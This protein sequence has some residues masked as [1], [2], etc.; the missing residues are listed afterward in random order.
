VRTENL[1]GFQSVNDPEKP[2]NSLKGANRERIL[3]Q[4]VDAVESALLKP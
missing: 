2:L 4:V 3:T 1:N